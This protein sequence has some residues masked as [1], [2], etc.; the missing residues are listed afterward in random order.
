MLY[1]SNKMNWSQRSVSLSDSPRLKPTPLMA[2]YQGMD[3]CKIFKFFV[4]QIFVL[5]LIYRVGSII[6]FLFKDV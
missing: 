5:F 1:Y 2:T 6:R 4:C 3:F